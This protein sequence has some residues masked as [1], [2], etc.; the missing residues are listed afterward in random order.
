MSIRP[1]NYHRHH[2]T[3]K[4]ERDLVDLRVFIEREFFMQFRVFQNGAIEDIF[5]SGLE[6][7][8]DI[9]IAQDLFAF[10]LMNVAVQLQNDVI[11]RQR[12]GLVR[13]KHIHRAEVLNRVQPLDDDLLA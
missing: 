6:M 1:I 2:S 4:I 5:Q 13:A 7:A 9:C 10:F 8:D 12:A 11:H 3:R